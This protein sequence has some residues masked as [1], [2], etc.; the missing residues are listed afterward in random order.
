MSNTKQIEWN[1]RGATRIDGTENQN[2]YPV[3]AKM[4]EKHCRENGISIT[5]D[6]TGCYTHIA[7]IP[8]NIFAA[9]IFS[10]RAILKQEPARIA[11]ATVARGKTIKT[12]IEQ[13][14]RD[15]A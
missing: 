4:I 1:R 6:W 15:N 2:S 8:E 12:E 5:T 11:S 9:I 7:A 13:A 10:V 3:V 14:R